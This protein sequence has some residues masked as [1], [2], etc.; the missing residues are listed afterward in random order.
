MGNSPVSTILLI[1]LMVVAFYFL[2]LRPQKKRQQAQQ[3]TM[4][5]IVPGTRVLLGS[6][7]FGTVV[8]TGEKQ[9]VLETSPGVHVT[10]LKQAI[11]RVIRPGDE[12]S[13]PIETDDEIDDEIVDQDAVEPAHSDDAYRPSTSEYGTT[14]Y[15]RPEYDRPVADNP[16]FGNEP[17]NKD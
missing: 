5:E 1:A 13:E 17:K 12:F 2:L 15:D 10:V 11:A 4:N 7:I 14:E 9:A 8:S 3:K 16:T 6:G